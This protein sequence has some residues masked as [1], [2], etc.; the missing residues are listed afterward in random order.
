MHTIRFN[1]VYINLHD[2]KEISE[3]KTGNDLWFELGHY[4]SY[5]S[6]TLNNNKKYRSKKYISYNE[7]NHDRIIL[8]KL[9]KDICS[10]HQ[11][12]SSRAQINFQSVMVFQSIYLVYMF[13]II[14]IINFQR[15]VLKK[16]LYL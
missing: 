15:S 16:K 8:E 11:F 10:K 14:F 9:M 6:I 3:V 13:A 7:A 2:I 4:F 5:F 1:K 12:D